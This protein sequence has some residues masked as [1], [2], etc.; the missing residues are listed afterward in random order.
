MCIR[1]RENTILVGG[2]R[3]NLPRM[4][5]SNTQL[6]KLYGIGQ[7]TISYRLSDWVF[8]ANFGGKY[9]SL[10]SLDSN[11]S[12]VSTAD[13]LTNQTNISAFIGSQVSYHL[14]ENL[15]IGLGYRRGF[16]NIERNQVSISLGITL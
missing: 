12:A 7:I 2:L 5:F 16:E 11:P 14:S 10:R 6:K 13:A 9:N 3:N 1:D 4:S 15:D 8:A